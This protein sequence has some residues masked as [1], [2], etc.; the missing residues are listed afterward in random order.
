MHS[1][2]RLLSC[3]RR[4]LLGA[5][6]VC[7]AMVGQAQTPQE[8]E[9][10][11]EIQRTLERIPH[12]VSVSDFPSVPHF[13]CLN[14]GKTL[15][16]WSFA[17]GSFLESEMARL[18]LP[19]VHLSVM[20]PTYC[21]WLEKARRF[22]KTKGDSRFNPGDL[23]T[24]VPEACQE[25][26]EMPASV[27]DKES[28]QALPDQTRLYAE[29]ETLMKKVKRSGDWNEERVLGQ[30]KAILNRWLGEPPKS[31]SFEGKTYTPRSFADEVIRLPW[32]DYVLLTSFESAPFNAFT[33]FKVPDNWHHNTNYFNLPLVQFYNAFKEAV[34]NGFSVAVSIDT[35]EPSYRQTG[36]Y[37]VVLD[38]DI[39]V[40]A[41][42]QTEREIRFLTGATTDDHAIHIIGYK[43][44]NGEDWFLAKDSW[45][46]TWKDNNHGD[47]FLHRSYVKLKILAFIV[48]RDGVSGIVPPRS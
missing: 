5:L 25:Y 48:H 38:S 29:L 23:F 33:E 2:Y 36:R 18:G 12:P 7:L 19:S 40:E 41:I 22:V 8:K 35:S 4:T 14:Q 27:Y 45:K 13:A 1:C 37:C 15:V 20:Y 31:F 9:V 32:A 28:A 10:Q 46:T 30:V 21:Q 11:E 34:S 16:C 47:L 43:N 6:A 39:P 26:G 17:T 44:F 24:G 42:G 3:K